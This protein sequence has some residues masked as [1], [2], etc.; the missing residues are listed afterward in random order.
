LPDNRGGWP[1]PDSP[2]VFKE[3][4]LQNVIDFQATSRLSNLYA[5]RIIKPEYENIAVVRLYIKL[6]DDNYTQYT[7]DLIFANKSLYGSIEKYF[8]DFNPDNVVEM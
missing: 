2:G 7:N 8:L 1:P 4:L 5:A 3:V 6:E